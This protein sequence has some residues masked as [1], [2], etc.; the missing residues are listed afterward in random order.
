MVTVALKNN[1]LSNLPTYLSTYL[2]LFITYL[3]TYPN[4]PIYVPIYLNL[5]TYLSTYLSINLSI[6]TCMRWRLFDVPH[7]MRY[8]TSGRR[9]VRPSRMRESTEKLKP[10]ETAAREKLTCVRP[11]REKLQH[12]ALYVPCAAT[13]VSVSAERTTTTARRK[14]RV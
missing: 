14:A 9:T 8:A 11:C 7:G 6:I 4:L 2:Y 3:P 5:P 13:G 10:A 1:Y 12:A